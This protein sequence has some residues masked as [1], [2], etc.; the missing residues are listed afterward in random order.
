MIYEQEEQQDPKPKY[1]LTISL[2]VLNHLGIGLYSNVPAILSE[3]VANAWDADA[4]RVDITIDSHKGEIVVQDDGHGMTASDINE[5]YLCVGYQKREKEPPKTPKGRLP[6][7]RKGIGKLSVFSIANFVEV[8]SVKNG[9]ASGLLMNLYDIKQ[10]IRGGEGTYHPIPI[11]PPAI[12][13]TR[14]T[15]I[16]L[17]DLRKPVMVAETYLRKRLARRFSVLGGKEFRVF[18]NGVE[19]TVKDRDFFDHV[20]MLWYFGAESADVALKCKNAK[21]VIS[22]SNVVN[23]TKG[24]TVKGWVAT[25]VNQQAIDETNNNIIIFARGKLIQEDMLSDFKEGGLFSKY[26][27]GEIDA[28]FMDLDEYEDIVTSNRQSVKEDDSRYTELREF[29]QRVLKQVQADWGNYRTSA[30][31]DK[32]LQNPAIKQWYG[33]LTTGRKKYAQGLFGKIESLKGVDEEAKRQLYKHTLLAFEKLALTD[34]LGFLESLE[35][36]KDFAMLTE[37]FHGIDDIEAVHYHQ[38]AKGRLEIL[39]HFDQ[40]LNRDAEIKERVLQEYLFDHL[41]LLS[42]SWERATVDARME[43]SLG[44]EFDVVA[45][46]LTEDERRGRL[47]IRYRTAANKHIVIELK[48][49]NRRVGISELVDQ[50][51]KYQGALTKCL[52]T[53]HPSAPHLIE[54]IC[55]LGYH[56]T[57][58]SNLRQHA[59]LLKVC[60]ARYV[61]YDE[62]INEALLGYQD[63]LTRTQEISEI[64]RLIES[65]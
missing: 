16:T 3:V 44:R 60:N 18:L 25:A 21:R 32:A 51:M 8:Q 65:I 57:P 59:E 22:L 61:L 5:K 39:K 54:I 34:T 36:E 26:L 33:R 6:M 10:K 27:I 9:E 43:E 46:G 41:W 2:N 29:V 12:L 56:P 28:D 20:E 62:L 55:I 47:D 37:L 40:L 31:T 7:G 15:K 17:T 49:Y 30:G 58:E 48:K 64:V 45:A 19:I 38:I 63:Y 1:A 52:N 42:P 35:T 50:V 23:E 53:H 4:S 14:G 24:Y 11:D 13:I